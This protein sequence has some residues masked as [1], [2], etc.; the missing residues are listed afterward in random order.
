MW[1]ICFI[2][3]A[4]KK[5]QVVNHSL[6]LKLYLF[7]GQILPSLPWPC[8]AT[9][10]KRWETNVCTKTSCLPF[11]PS[12]HPCLTKQSQIKGAVG[13]HQH[14]LRLVQRKSCQLRA[15]WFEA[16]FT[17]IA[18]VKCWQGWCYTPATEVQS[19]LPAGYWQSERSHWCRTTA[20][21]FWSSLWTTRRVS[22]ETQSRKTAALFGRHW[23]CSCW[24]H[25]KW[26]FLSNSKNHP[27]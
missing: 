18:K 8:T 11:C 1:D 6:P 17:L 5:P 22:V 16:C 4:Q 2:Y 7:F 13:D 19:P 27:L 20:G 12:P 14:A 25:V 23:R 9:Y 15:L 3:A 24:F 21:R 10:T 26:H